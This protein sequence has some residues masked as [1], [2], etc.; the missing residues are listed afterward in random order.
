MKRL[1]GRIWQRL[2]GQ[3]ELVGERALQVISTPALL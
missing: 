3:P 1:S 2:V